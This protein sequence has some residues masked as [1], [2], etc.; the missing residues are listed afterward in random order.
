VRVAKPAHQA[1]VIAKD[2]NQTSL[3]NTQIPMG[4]PLQAAGL[5]D[6]AGVWLNIWNYPEGDLDSYFANLQVN[7]IRN[8]FI[9][10][11]RS[12]TSALPK[13]KEL[14]EIIEACHRHQINVVAW[15][16]NDLKNPE[17]DA[18]KLIQAARYTSPN[19]E[20]I[21]AVA[22]D[23]E[24][25]LDKWRVERF[26]NR[27]RANLGPHYPLIAVVFSPLNLASQAALTPWRSI[28]SQWNVV[29][30]MTYWSGK[31]QRIDAYTYTMKTIQRIRELTNRSDIDIHVIGDGMYSTGAQIQQFLKACKDAE[32]SSASLYPNH[33]LTQDQLVTMSRY[34]DYFQPNSQFRLAAYRELK[35][36]GLMTE[37]DKNDPSKYISKGEFYKIAVQ[38][39]INH[40]APAGHTKPTAA[41]NMPYLSAQEAKSLSAQQAYDTLTGLQLVQ[42]APIVGIESLSGPIY[43]DEAMTL[44]GNIANLQ[45]TSKSKVSHKKRVFIQPAYA[46]NRQTKATAKPLNFI[47]AAE[48]LV[49]SRAGLP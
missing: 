30:P 45:N 27:L 46:E 17:A 5:A 41:G 44:L 25:L 24:L 49:L 47:D 1:S 26:S 10:T 42:A 32:V 37:P 34:P 3:Q 20:R 43:A 28:I 14:G 18:D 21:D 31:N 22:G 4:A 15:S 36:T 48:L 33:K 16:F 13:A 39:L 29:A 2:T 40:K 8:F 9:Q 11:S 23:I 38:H 12:N 35:N 7:G 6:G 19:G